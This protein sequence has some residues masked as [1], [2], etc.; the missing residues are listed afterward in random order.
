[1]SEGQLIRA[2]LRGIQ[3]TPDLN[4]ALSWLGHNQANV[5]ALTQESITQLNVADVYRFYAAGQ[6]DRPQAI[7][8]I[9]KTGTDEPTASLMLEAADLADGA[10]PVQEQ[11][12][13]LTSAFL[14]RQIDSQTYQTFLSQL[15]ISTARQAQLVSYTTQRIEL[16]TKQLT[17]AEM[18]SAFLD[19][20]IDLTELETFLL[21]EGYTT[22]AAQLYVIQ[23]LSKLTTHDAQVQVAQ[24]KY[25][26]AVASAKA[27]GEPIPP[28][29]AIL[30][31]P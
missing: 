22:A 15:P 27:K 1:L 10:A 18:Q 11:V 12:A 14:A 3:T 7:Q 2:S 13:Y 20:L 16:P 24:Y 25:N 28:K 8:Y 17:L 9:V 21:A 30:A 5:D 4:T 23:T 29:P 6:I 19:G 26:K 31:G